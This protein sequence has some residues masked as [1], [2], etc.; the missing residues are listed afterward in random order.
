MLHRRGKQSDSPMSMWKHC[1]VTTKKCSFSSMRNHAFIISCSVLIFCVLCGAGIAITFVFSNANEETQRNEALGLAEETGAWF[2]DQLDQAILPL[3]SMAQFASELEIF[4]NLPTKIGPA[5]DQNSLPFVEPQN[6]GDAYSHRNV[7][8]VCDDPAV[9]SRFTEIASTIKK[10]AKMQGVLV[11]LQL[12]PQAVVC[13]LHPINNTEDFDNGVFM[14]NSGALGLDLLTDPK[15][16][17][18]AEQTI[19]QDDIIIAGPLTLR[20]CRDATK[21]DATVNKAFIARLPISVPDYQIT[22][23]GVAYNKW[24]FATALI[25]WEALVTRSKVYENFAQR[26]LEFQL[27]RTDRNFNATSQQYDEHIVVLAETP[28]YHW[29]ENCDCRV[30]TALQTTNNEWEITV[31]YDDSRTRRTKIWVICAVVLLAFSI[32]ALAHVVMMQ[33]QRHGYM[34]GRTLAQ[35]AKVETE[36]N[37]TAYFA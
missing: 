6:P 7:T 11:N 9:V 35:S 16:K 23:N 26:G 30:T 18:I 28:G 29:N 31:I 36:R 21:C 1:S 33:K 12:A 3:F 5:F 13:L 4:R 25:N 14:D 27:T 24:G 2:S 37:M 34:V 8:G 17:F 32:S 20:Q 10:L 19:R 15:N 22:V